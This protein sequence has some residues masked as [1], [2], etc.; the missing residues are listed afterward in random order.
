MNP[1]H[2]KGLYTHCS[3]QSSDSKLEAEKKSEINNN[4]FKH[5]SSQLFDP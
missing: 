5:V 1:H 4:H 2:K 3:L